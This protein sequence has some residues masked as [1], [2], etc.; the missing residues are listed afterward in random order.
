[1]PKPFLL[2]IDQGTSGS[3]AVILDREGGVRGFAYRPLSRIH[4]HPDWVEQD[5]AEVA[6]GVAEAITEAIG[7]AGC[8]PDDIAACGIASQRNTDFVWDGRNGRSLANAIT[9][10]DLRILPLLRDLEQWPHRADI[11]HRLGY[12]PGAYMAAL[13][14]AWRMKEDSAVLQAARQGYLRIG[15]SASWLIQAL[16][17]P[18]GHYLDTSLV[19]AM[20]VYD[21]RA[22]QYWQEWLEWLQ[23]PCEPL[24]TAVPTLYD[25]GVIGVSAPD[26][27]TAEIPVLATIGDQQAALFGQGCRTPGDAECTHGTASYVKV[28]TGNHAPM[29]ET[30]DVLCA[31]HLGDQ[32]T[33]CLEASTTVNGAAI[34]WMR[35]HAR[36]FDSYEEIDLLAGSVA[37]SGGVVFVPAFTG[38][39]A[40]YQD[41]NTRATLLGMTLG[42]T[43][44]HI[45]R[46]FLEAIGYQI[47]AI[48]E[49]IAADS[50]TQVEQLLVGGGVSASDVACQIQADVV[51]IPV[52]R[53]TFTE[54]TARAAALLAGLGAGVWQKTA[55]L[56]PQPGS[57]TRFEPQ[58]GEE[59]R[60]AGNGRWQKAIRLAQ[61]WG[62]EQGD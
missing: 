48:L 19:Q 21:F 43:R 32:Q 33:Y 47:R 53:P 3:K 49:R 36:L 51:G 23:V 35:D 15:S 13:H 26:G 58:M 2:G 37:N 44:A 45:V 31:W 41:P 12:G 40:P 18:A 17:K 28:F 46:A 8:R 10:Q 20:G 25:F 9:W 56:P 1:M 7:Q 55:D 14:L 54:T 29:Q 61:Q 42:H 38:L 34:R 50:G 30:V 6:S 52:V 16:G 11:H 5:P 27:K 59:E 62:R 24:P 57:Y 60:E 22:G 39:N 4:P